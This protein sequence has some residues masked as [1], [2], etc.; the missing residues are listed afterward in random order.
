MVANNDGSIVYFDGPVIFSEKKFNRPSVPKRSTDEDAEADEFIHW[1]DYNDFPLVARELKESSPDLVSALDWKARALYAS[2]ISFSI[3]DP[4]TEEALPPTPE[5]RKLAF[6]VQRFLFDN[7]SYL[8]AAAIDITDL[9]HGFAEM[10]L[11]ESRTEIKRINCLPGYQCRLSKKN[12]DGL[13]P[14]VFVHP[15]WA[16]HLGKGD[17][18]Q[19]KIPAINP[20]VHS[21]EDIREETG[22]SFRYVY[23]LLYP[24]S[25]P[26]YQLPH[27]FSIKKSGWLDFGNMIPEMKKAILTNLTLIRYHIQMPDY[28]MT[29]RYKNWG[30]MT[31]A[32]RVAAIKKEFK[33]INDVLTGPSNAGKSIYTMFKTMTA[34]GKEYAGWKI[35]PVDDKMKDGALL[36]D[37]SEATIKVFSATSIDPSLHGIIPGKG[38]SNRSGSDKRE[39]LNIYM[40]LS[41]AISD[42]LL[43]PFRF[44]GWYNGW[45]TADRMVKLDIQKPILQTLNAVTPSKRET[46][47]EK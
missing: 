6:K 16:N 46:T 28:W 42:I 26:S 13:I 27:W 40:S 9:F 14:F 36:A 18:K 2:G 38:G 4:F 41:T 34:T 43:E 5:I 45:N 47:E 39:A 19:Q 7:R 44:A 3:V 11:D 31:D 10:I 17:K 21:P 22:G 15:D 33:V 25:K 23:P 37:S 32:T 30:S 29:D 1:G 8:L 20:M 12:P 24:A 35:T